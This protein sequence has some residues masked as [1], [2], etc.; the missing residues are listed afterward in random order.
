MTVFSVNKCQL[1]DRAYGKSAAF[2]FS[3]DLA[4][5]VCR[6]EEGGNE[7]KMSFKNKGIFQ[8]IG[9]LCV[10]GNICT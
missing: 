6:G 7:R 8:Q 5:L 3:I 4:S 1:E 10:S 9:E 2:E